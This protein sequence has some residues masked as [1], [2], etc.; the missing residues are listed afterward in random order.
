[1]TSLTN[2][3]RQ[4]EH[5]WQEGAIRIEDVV[6]ICCGLYPGFLEGLLLF[7]FSFQGQT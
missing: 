2:K 3:H 5:A 4:S 1:M 7:K 6:E